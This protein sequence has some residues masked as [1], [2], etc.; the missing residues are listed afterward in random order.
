MS[1]TIR[2]FQNTDAAETA[3]IIEKNLLISNRPDYSDADI[4]EMITLYSRDGVLE[5]AETSHFYVICDREAIIGCGGIAEYMGNPTE[6]ILVTVFLLPEYQG[7]GVGRLI[8]E[9]LEQDEYFLRASRIVIHSSI[10]AHMFYKKLGYT[11]AD[12]SAVPDEEG[13]IRMEKRR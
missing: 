8:M 4:Q 12:G 13:C 7:K 5:R 10:T 11:Y 3:G 9:T 2:R 1:F 6:S